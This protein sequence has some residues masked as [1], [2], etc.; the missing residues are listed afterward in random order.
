MARHSLK[1][2]LGF[3]IA[4]LAFPCHGQTPQPVSPCELWKNP[5]PYSGKVVTV[6]AGVSIGF[7]NFSLLTPGCEET[8]RPIWLAYGGDEPTPTVSTVNDRSRTPGSVLKVNGRPVILH[9]NDALELFQRRLSAERLGGITGQG[10][11]YE[12]RL[13]RV[14]ATLTGVFFAASARPL[15]GYGHLGCCHLLAIEEVADVD[16]QRNQVPVGGRFTCSTDSFQIDSA[17]A[18]A[19]EEKRERCHGFNECRQASLEE[20]AEVA[21]HWE[22]SVDQ[23]DRGSVEPY[24]DT[25]WIS[26]DL[27]KSYSIQTQIKESEHNR[28]PIT[29][30]MTVSRSVCKALAPPLPITPPTCSTNLW[31]QLPP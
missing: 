16:A 5:A 31:P 19:L 26:P 8:A 22:P 18:Q 15:A 3:L 21:R 23:L 11:P 10:C 12:C 6:T 30:G 27:L 24:Q 17:E 29:T 14:T 7:E 25:N 2:C 20:I 4:M 28:G 9:R 13:Y 1:A